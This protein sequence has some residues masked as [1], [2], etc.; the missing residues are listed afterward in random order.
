MAK[1][2]IDL[3]HSGVQFS[4]R[5]VV[6]SKVRGRFTRFTGAI[7]FDAAAPASATIRASIE[8]GSIDTSEAKRD[9]HLRSAEFLDVDKFPAITYASK[10][11]TPAGE[12][13]FQVTGDLTLHGVTREVV[14]DAEYLGAGKDPWGAQRAGFAARTRIDRKDFGLKWNQL[15]EAG[16]VLVGE[17]IDIE[18]EIEAVAA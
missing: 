5:H 14:L 6:I 16:G 10:S 1:W 12:G 18:L 17:N 15:L 3:S 7:D 13:R 11:I 9:G 2:N 4:V 8:A